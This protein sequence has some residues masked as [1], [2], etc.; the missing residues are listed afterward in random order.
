MLSN[1]LKVP[2]HESAGKNQYQDLNITPVGYQKFKKMNLDPPQGS[3]RVTQSSVKRYAALPRLTVASSFSREAKWLRFRIVPPV[4]G[5]PRDTPPFPVCLARSVL[6]YPPLGPCNHQ[7]PPYRCN[8]RWGD[9]AS[10]RA[11]RTG[12]GGVS[13]GNGNEGGRRCIVSLY[14]ISTM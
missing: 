7:V 2:S 13:L 12:N 9:P 10:R 14:P 1:V 11:K 4:L 3:C 6:G 8:V 5:Y